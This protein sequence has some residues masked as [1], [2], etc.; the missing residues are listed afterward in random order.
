MSHYITLQRH[1]DGE[2]IFRIEGNREFLTVT[3]HPDNKR[4][5]S[6]LKGDAQVF[7]PGVNSRE[8]AC[9]KLGMNGKMDVS[10]FLEPHQY[11]SAAETL[12]KMAEALEEGA[13][14]EEEQAA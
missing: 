11:I 13:E 7:P 10:F 4:S 5:K 3:V 8:F 9:V 14:K 6:V 2:I 1:T 12:R